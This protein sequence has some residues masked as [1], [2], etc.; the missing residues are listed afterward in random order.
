[1]TDDTFERT[2]GAPYGAV[3]SLVEIRHPWVIRTGGAG[4]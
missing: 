2:G 4:R 3:I 1:M